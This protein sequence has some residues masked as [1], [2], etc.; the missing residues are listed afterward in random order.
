MI[1]VLIRPKP[2]APAISALSYCVGAPAIPLSASPLQGHSLNWY[3]DST[4]NAKL[5]NAPTPNTNTPG[6][7]I[8]Y[9]SQTNAATG[10]EGVR[11]PVITTVNALP[12]KPEVANRIYCAGASSTALTA[13][14]ASGHVL[15]WYA[16][17]I[18][19]TSPTAAPVPNTSTIGKVVYFVSQTNT[20]TGCE[21]PRAALEV[22]VNAKPDVPTTTDLVVCQGTPSP[23]LTA[24][25]ISG[26]QLKWYADSLTANALPA[27]PS[28]NTGSAFSKM[29]YLTQVDGSS[30]CE[31]NRVG[32]KVTINAI[33]AS[34][35]TAA[36]P[37]YCQ[38][39]QASQLT[40]NPLQGHTLN[41]YADSLNPTP[42]P[43]TPTPQTVNQGV[44]Q[45]YVSQTSTS[46]GCESKRSVMTVSI[47]Q[48]PT[49][50]SASA[51]NYSQGATATPLVATASA[52]NVL[53]WYATNTQTNALPSAPVPSTVATGTTA[54]Y[55]S[56]QSSSTGCES[57][58]TKLDVVIS[59][60][61]P[62]PVISR[63]GAGA[64]VSSVSQGLQWYKEGVLINGA[65]SA[66]YKPTEPAY[67]SVKTNQSGCVST[68][69]AYYYLVTALESWLP[70]G[71]FIRVFPN[72]VLT[73]LEIRHNIDLQ[74]PMECIVLDA[75]GKTVMKTLISQK[76]SM[77]NLSGL[78]NGNYQ[79][80]IYRTPAALL[81]KAYFIKM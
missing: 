80:L 24:T 77:L 47:L 36:V 13:T 16:D 76:E 75:A 65:T 79:L 67:Y 54:Y 38:G 10:C 45:Y 41:W 69:V 5:Q 72:P 2:A 71:K 22:V 14:A 70:A 30:G 42:L 29:Y 34:P 23:V 61:P 6:T 28:I 3:A 35:S 33:P 49:P 27:A 19:A 64:L 59:P 4:S 9:V 52:G 66:T 43:S 7:Q 8:Y 74:E 57:N 31:S 40:A 73:N 11:T 46:T 55:V 51:V 37:A 12:L 58:R 56:Q 25:A 18:V 39:V 1:R 48:L 26:N 32:L 17:S 21:G 78:V 81:F 60:I 62:I 63:D 15:K 50:P 44:Q 53:K 20:S 68:S